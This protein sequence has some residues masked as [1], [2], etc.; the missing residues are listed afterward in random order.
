LE[1][2]TTA[3]PAVTPAWQTAW[4]LLAPSQ[5]RA[6]L[7]LFV[8]MLLGM[9]IESLGLGMVLPALAF[10]ANDDP[11]S[12][13]PALAALLH[14]LGNPSRESLILSGL[15]AVLAIA[16]GKAAFMV[17]LAWEQSK[18]LADLG[19]SFGQR[20]FSSY[21]SQPWTFHLQRNSA[22]LCRNVTT[23]V[24]LFVT[25]LNGWLNCLADLL[26]LLGITAVLLAV[27]PV[28][29]VVVASVLGLSTLL[30]QRLTK[31]A[32]SRWG[33]ARQYHEG[34]K[35]QH[36]LQGLHGFKDVRILGREADFIRT[37]A[38]HNATVARVSQ[39]QSLVIQLPRLWYELVAAAGLCLLACTMLLLKTPTAVFIPTIG[40]FAMA[41][42]RLLPS[43]NRL[44]LNLQNI[45]FMAPAVNVIATELSQGTATALP[46]DRRRARFTTALELRGVTYRYP[47][48]AVE[49]VKN[50]S[51]T[52]PHGASVG[53]IGES[54]AGKSTLVDLILGLL[55]PTDGKI[56]LDGVDIAAD[57]RAWQN[58]IGYVPQSI[59]LSDDSLRRNVAF[60]Q[61]DDEI[62]DAK[63][64]TSLDA[65]QL[66]G[67]LSTLPDGLNTFVGERGIRLSGG[68]RQR[69]GIAR[70]LYHE[71]EVLILDEATSALDTDTESGVMACVNALQG[72]KTLIIVAHRL[73]T[74]A[75]CDL[76]Y[77]INAGE[78][79]AAGSPDVVLRTTSDEPLQDL[80]T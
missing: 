16:A 32:V 78:I 35:F 46:N 65:A 69:I 64:L 18:V 7:M 23:E 17:F 74:V 75:K 39:R 30:F 34:Q 33:A 77:R 13:S 21:M 9:L 68:Q 36:L 31:P 19:A 79:V 49:S 67:F 8:L 28:G 15:G 11:G 48:A 52:V 62:D 42:F 70:A 3:V 45:R 55:E 2:P 40:L 54:G 26:M 24:S 80:A 66:S 63:V 27:Q 22:Q 61:P 58:L 25:A 6:T 51:L 72:S 44:V 14:K 60:G 57:L 41:A 71:P 37:F 73:S 10:M 29:A 38:T 47:Q 76:L 50:L 43:I 53:L 4:R 20:L 1:L 56:L 5:R 12:L 59:Y